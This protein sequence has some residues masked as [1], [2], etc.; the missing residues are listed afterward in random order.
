MFIQEYCSFM[1]VMQVP[2][3]RLNTLFTPLLASICYLLRGKVHFCVMFYFT[4]C[5]ILGYISVKV[6]GKTLFSSYVS[7][8]HLLT[9]HI[10]V[11]LISSLFH[12]II[13]NMTQYNYKDYANLVKYMTLHF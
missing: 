8:S 2:C 6:L 3:F 4:L 12:Y 5:H 13:L 1:Y 7:S 11:I 10:R 9:S